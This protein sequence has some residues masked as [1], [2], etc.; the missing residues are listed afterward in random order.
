MTPERPELPL[1]A[2]SVRFRG[3]P[4]RPRKASQSG[5]ASSPQAGY[6]PAITPLR[7]RV[8]TGAADRARAREAPALPPLAP[9]LLDVAAAAEYLSVSPWTVRDLVSAGRLARVR[10]PLA[11]ER[12]CRRLL[13]D[14]RDLDKLI[15]A[16]KEGA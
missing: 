10:L 3:K 2:A 1:A 7:T 6:V 11:G 15:E 4:G 12:E 8:S 16:A 14:V 9:R 13:V 5:G